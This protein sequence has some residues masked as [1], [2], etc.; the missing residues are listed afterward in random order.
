[1]ILALA[2]R[3]SV[4]RPAISMEGGKAYGAALPAAV[5]EAFEKMIK[6][7]TDLRRMF[8]AS[9]DEM[10]LTVRRIYDIG[11]EVSEHDKKAVLFCCAGPAAGRG[12]CPASVQAPRR[13]DRSCLSGQ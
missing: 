13:A 5:C 8:R 6:V 2:M 1:M 10:R 12:R 7:L 4:E 9:F 11:K 3:H